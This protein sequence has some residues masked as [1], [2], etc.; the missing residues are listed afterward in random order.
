MESSNDN[1]ICDASIPEQYH[2]QYD[3]AEDIVACTPC[4][5]C[6]ESVALKRFESGPRICTECKEAILRL[7][8]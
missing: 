7:R 5:V 4:L 1:K 8:K 3:P 6:G 2:Y